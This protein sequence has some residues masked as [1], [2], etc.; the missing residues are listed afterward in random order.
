MRLEGTLRAKKKKPFKGTVLKR[1]LTPGRV[2]ALRLRLPTKPKGRLKTVFVTG[3]VRGETGAS[4]PV[5]L[6]VAVRR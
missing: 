5:K 4:R 3:T 2:L 1:A 6:A